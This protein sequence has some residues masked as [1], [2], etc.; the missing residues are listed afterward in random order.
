M[1]QIVATNLESVRK[2]GYQDSCTLQ[3]VE[4]G[5]SVLLKDHIDGVCDLRYIG[6]YRIVSFPGKTEV[7]VVDSVGK[8]K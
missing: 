3:E 5:D 4:K 2:N 7:K 8:T 1:Y 6:D